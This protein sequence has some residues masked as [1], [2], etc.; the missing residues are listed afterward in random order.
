MQHLASCQWGVMMHKKEYPR[1][2]FTR[3]FAIGVLLAAALLTWEFLGPQPGPRHIGRS[4]L[5]V[6]QASLD[7][8]RVKESGAQAYAN[9]IF[10]HHSTGERLIEAGHLREELRIHGYALWDHGYNFQGLHDPE[11]IPAGYS[12]NIPSDNTDPL[13]LAQILTQPHL[14]LPTNTLSG[15][16][17]HEVILLKSCFTPTSEIAD[18]ARLEAYMQA[19]LDM[20]TAIANHPEKL[21]II[22]TQP[23]LNPDATH[24]QQ[25]ARARKLADW[26]A[27]N[28][29]HGELDNLVVFDLFDRLAES[30]PSAPDFNMLRQE[31]RDGLDSHPNQLANETIAPVLADFIIQAIER[32]RQAIREGTFSLHSSS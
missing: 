25:A 22:L 26:L 23:P 21:F 16:L 7:S 1:S 30:D 19:Y 13:G 2:G 29:F 31:Y 32:Y 27:S 20:R 4:L 12:Y 11:G 15:L 18:D 5:S 8:R 6:L 28:D 24:P 17:Q 14:P 3:F 10:L 9:I